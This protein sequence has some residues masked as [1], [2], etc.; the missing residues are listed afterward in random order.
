LG[1]ISVIT[2]EKA[3]TFSG[4]IVTAPAPCA[5]AFKRGL[6]FFTVGFQDCNLLVEQI[7]EFY[8]T[9]GYRLVEPFEFLLCGRDLGLQ[10][11]EGG[12]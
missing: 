1:S 11:N 5:P 9:V 2:R 4:S 3:S 12:R 6:G 8:D 10:R 7:V